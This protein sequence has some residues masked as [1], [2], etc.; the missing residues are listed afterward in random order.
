M[1]LLIFRLL[2]LARVSRRPCG[3]LHVGLC[4]S[5]CSIF[6]HSDVR[7][8]ARPANPR[9]IVGDVFL[10]KCE[11][12]EPPSSPPDPLAL[13]HVSPDRLR[14]DYSVYDLKRNV[15][16]PSRCPD[17]RLLTSNPTRRPS[18]SPSPAKASARFASR[19]SPPPRM[20]CFSLSFLYP[21]LL[22][23]RTETPTTPR[24][25]FPRLASPLSLLLSPPR[26]RQEMFRRKYVT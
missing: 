22:T 24:S 12:P 17:R 13:T 10:R 5:I 26:P 18:D 1:P 21:S 8:L 25:P 3:Q 6:T 19:K 4:F 14:T 16:S 2:T 9:E 15:R 23:R 20:S 11:S 7:Q